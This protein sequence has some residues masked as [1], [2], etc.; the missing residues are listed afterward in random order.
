MGGDRHRNYKYEEAEEK[1]KS[2]K[3]GLWKYNL[4]LNSIKG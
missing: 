3:V 2:N 4:N 1:A